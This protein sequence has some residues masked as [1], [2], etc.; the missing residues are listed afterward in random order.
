MNRFHLF[1]SLLAVLGLAL[2]A[3]TAGA[4]LLAYESFETEATGAFDGTAD[5]TW[6]LG[7]TTET[8]ENKDLSYSGG[9][10]TVGSGDRA[11]KLTD[12]T[13]FIGKAVSFDFSAQTGT[14]YFSFL[15]QIE[16][17]FF[18]PWV[19]YSAAGG[20]EPQFGSGQISMDGRATD[21]IK[22]T[23]IN[24]SPLASISTADLGD[25]KAA[26][27]FVVAKLSKSGAAGANYDQLQVVVNPTSITEPGT[28]A[29]D[30]TK[31]IQVSSLDRFA[32]RYGNTAAG[33]WIDEIR[34]GTTYGSVIPEPSTLALGLLALVGLALYRRRR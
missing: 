3:G 14:V 15:T 4:A 19:G 1:L 6:T 31:D 30:I 11:L 29:G 12:A 25:P 32:V 17:T 21:S 18:Q 5:Q 34:I 7:T 27:V 13:A 28:W 9:D 20:A 22:G 10:I 33:G 24:I 26:P 23:L 2:F 8:I 16:A